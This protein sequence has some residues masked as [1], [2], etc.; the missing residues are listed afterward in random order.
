MDILVTWFYNGKVYHKIK[1]NLNK[2]A[3]RKK[4]WNF[5]PWKSMFWS[6]FKSSSKKDLFGIV[7]RKQWSVLRL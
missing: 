1:K 5:L 2:S 4:L 6:I 3:Y 7:S